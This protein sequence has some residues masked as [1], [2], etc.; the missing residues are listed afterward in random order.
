MSLSMIKPSILAQLELFILLVYY[1]IKDCYLVDCCCLEVSEARALLQS[2]CKNNGLESDVLVVISIGM[3]IFVVNKPNLLQKLADVAAHRSNLIIVN[4]AGNSMSFARTLE[5]EDILTELYTCISS[6]LPACPQPTEVTLLELVLPESGQ[7][8]MPLVAGWLLG[9]PSVYQSLTSSDTSAPSGQMSMIELVKVSFTGKVTVPAPHAAANT[10]KHPK[11]TASEQ[12]KTQSK[13]A[14]VEILGFSIPA[15][16]LE[17]HLD[18][19]LAFDHAVECILLHL[20]QHIST[21]SQSNCVISVAD[22]EKRVTVN[23]VP[24]IVL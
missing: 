10:K 1:D 2:V 5:Q 19:N 15:A 14:E 9:Y 7:L 11:V 16:L 24:S 8:S 3:D 4:F 13:P 20:Q 17:A 21:L 6:Q 12:P 18:V 23:V 22:I